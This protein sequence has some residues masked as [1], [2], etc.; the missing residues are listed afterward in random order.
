MNKGTHIKN[1]ISYSGGSSSGGN[2]DI[3]EIKKAEYDALPDTKYTDG[4][5]YYI[6]DYTESGEN[7]NVYSLDEVLIGKFF[8]KNLYRRLWN[9]NILSIGTSEVNTN[10]SLLSNNI[11]SVVKATLYRMSPNSHICTQYNPA[12]TYPNYDNDRVYVKS[13]NNMVSYS[14]NKIWVALE[15]TKVGD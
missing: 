14:D 3:I 2:S 8:D 9:L 10:I 13:Y 15:Y 11:E 5:Q 7:S 6:T 4:K 1:G 12:M